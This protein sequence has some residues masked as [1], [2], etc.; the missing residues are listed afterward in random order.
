MDI[1]RGLPIISS[2]SALKY[3]SK[4]LNEEDIINVLSDIKHRIFPR[5]FERLSNLRD[6]SKKRGGL[7][8]I[9]IGVAAGEHAISLLENLN[10]ERLY[11]ID[12]YENYTSI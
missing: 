8:G 10:I 1:N 11:L 2:I 3:F 9:E 12:P 6:R 4:S 5:P 7:V